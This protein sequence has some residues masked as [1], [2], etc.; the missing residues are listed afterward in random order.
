MQHNIIQSYQTASGS[1]TGQVA[2][3][4]DAELNSDVDLAAAASNV[5]L[6]LAV[7]RLNI[8]SCALVCTGDCTVKTNSTGSP[9]ET[10][11]LT[12]N[13]PSI[14]KNATEAQA[15]FSA[16]LTKLY[17]SSTAGGKF[18]VRFLLDQTP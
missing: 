4:G 1:L 18:S 10:I 14:A 12:A 15:L 13:Q 17:L 3:T 8:K 2:V 5:E 9:S 11:N 7:T 6:D 16:N